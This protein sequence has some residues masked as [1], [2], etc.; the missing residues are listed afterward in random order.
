MSQISKNINKNFG[1]VI[2]K[3]PKSNSLSPDTIKCKRIGNYILSNT[4][5]TGTF[6]KVK[7]G[8]HLPTQQKVAIKILDKDKIKDESDIERISREIHILKNLRHNNIAQL[9]ENITSERH[10]YI[11]MEYVDG[12][13][14]FQ[15]IY[16]LKRLN[17]LKA[18]FLF[19]QLISA[20]EYIHTLGIVHRDIKPEN[21]LLT[22]DHKKVKLVDFG[23][24]NSYQHGTLI[25]TACGSPCYAAPEM[26]SGKKYNGLY[27]D[28][29][30][31]GVVLYCMLC[32]KLPFDDEKIEVLYRKIRSGNYIIPNYLSDIAQ[33]ALRRILTV[34]P[35]KR[36]KL[37]E[38]KIH[39]FF[40]LDKTPLERGILIGIE[41]IYVNYDIVKEIKEKYFENKDKVNENYI[42]ENIKQNYYNNIT[43]IYYLL[44]KKKEEE[45]R[46]EKENEKK[47]IICDNNNSNDSENKKNSTIF[48]L[49][50]VKKLSF[51][52]N[53]N[54]ESINLNNSNNRYNVVVINNF[55]GESNDN[56]NNNISI[57]TNKKKVNENNIVS[58]NLD[59]QNKI[60]TKINL[61]K[62]ISSHLKKNHNS[63]N[64][65]N[66]ISQKNN[67]VSL[68]GNQN[69]NNTIM[70]NT[71]N[72]ENTVNTYKI[73]IKK[74]MKKF[75]FNSPTPSE[76][77]L[78]LI[79]KNKNKKSKPRTTNLS[80]NIKTI[81]QARTQFKN[82]G[83][84]KRENL[85]KYVNKL[86]V[87]KLFENEHSFNKESNIN[88]GSNNLNNM[89]LNLTS[90][91]SNPKKKLFNLKSNSLNRKPLKS[92]QNSKQT[93]KNHSNVSEFDNSQQKNFLKN[94][95]PKNTESKK[96]NHVFRNRYSLNLKTQNNSKE[97]G[98]N[99]KKNFKTNSLSKEKEKNSM[100]R[101]TNIEY[102]NNTKTL[103]NEPK[104]SNQKIIKN[105]NSINQ[106]IKAKKNNLIGIHSINFGN[107][108]KKNNNSKDN[109][110]Q[111]LNIKNFSI[112]HQKKFKF[113]KS[114]TTHN[115]KE[116]NTSTI[117]SSCLN[118]PKAIN[119]NSLLNKIPKKNLSIKI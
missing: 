88:N 61:N 16:S 69:I 84:S 22:K 95:I 19:R 43:A 11:V 118:K 59:S 23:L 106:S 37:K 92:T 71:T 67:T 42:I 105:N 38:L 110:K 13:D 45:S 99:L 113:L 80:R 116:K 34:N 65:S 52:N 103:M 63:R 57:S 68:G 24:S 50:N 7:L 31:C 74:D 112:N 39:P 93:S 107:M 83:K 117:K 77:N 4:I 2:I 26:I 46:L 70:N 66:L 109:K 47:K 98:N 53:Q 72:I 100:K 28:L 30:C 25:K 36:I 78:K 85:T 58:I 20:L 94:V 104:Y 5:G 62:F 8:I 40:N 15:Y 27:S 54:N 10:I 44:L 18:C 21:I 73:G 75:L 119:E 14:L 91:I 35:E 111:K 55:M 82:D 49:D 102:T 51:N 115:S 96:T 79:I 32:G 17:E 6:S 76:E 89:S 48:N 41:D 108:I 86:Y 101:N 29:W 97:K 60:T 1:H 114:I 81:N 56:H 64:L 9:Y 33:D 90:Y 12:K 87:K 3:Q